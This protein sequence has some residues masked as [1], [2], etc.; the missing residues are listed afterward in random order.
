M[1]LLMEFE[2]F[3]FFFYDFCFRSKLNQKRYRPALFLKFCILQPTS[4]SHLIY[5]IFLRMEDRFI[6]YYI[7]KI[8]K[9]IKQKKVQRHLTVV[10]HK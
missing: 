6:N 1:E 10:F 5:L 7:I 9:K 8:L 4:T 2:N 3:F